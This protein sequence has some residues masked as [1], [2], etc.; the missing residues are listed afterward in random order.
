VSTEPGPPGGRQPKLDPAREAEFLARVRASG[1]SVDRAGRFWHEGEPVE[2]EGLRQA[3]FR[4][5]D[6]LPEAQP[7]APP[8]PDDGRY[9]LRLDERRFA[10]IDV[11]DTPLVATS[12]RWDRGQPHGPVAQL[13]LNDGSEEALD[14]ASL[15]IDPGGVL[16]CWVRKGKLEARLATSAAATLAERITMQNGRP[17][18]LTAAGALPIAPRPQPPR[19]PGSASIAR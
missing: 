2:H 18:L 6:R 15:T 4:W 3:L 8:G 10:Y 7:P 5:L 1:I 14:P 11:D 16:R 12:L 9:I 17:H 19:P 13:G